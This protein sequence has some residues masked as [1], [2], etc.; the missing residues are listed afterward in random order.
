MGDFAT[1]CYNQNC[2]HAIIADSGPA[3]KFGEGS[4]R[5]AK[6]LR[7]NNSPKSGGVQGRVSYLV[8]PGSRTRRSRDIPSDAEIQRIGE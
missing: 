3:K 2:Y 8:Y 7:I 6:A 1:V 5:L 4:M